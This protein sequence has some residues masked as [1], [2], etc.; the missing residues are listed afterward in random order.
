MEQQAKV[1]RKRKKDQSEMVEEQKNT[2]AGRKKFLRLNLSSSEDRE[3]FEFKTNT[4]TCSSIRRLRGDTGVVGDAVQ[5]GGGVVRGGNEEVTVQNI[6]ERRAGLGE[7]I[8][9]DDRSRF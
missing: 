9:S 2:T 1:E 8:N 5:E 3:K 4:I 7:Q 6:T